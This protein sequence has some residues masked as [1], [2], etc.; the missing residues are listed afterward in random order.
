MFS[1][2]AAFVISLL[3]SKN[4][5]ASGSHLATPAE[6]ILCLLQNVRWI[7]KNLVIINYVTSCYKNSFPL[8]HLL[9]VTNIFHVFRTSFGSNKHLLVGSNIF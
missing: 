4:L 2:L 6:A 8:P 5:S 3:K 9:F 7:A 1:A